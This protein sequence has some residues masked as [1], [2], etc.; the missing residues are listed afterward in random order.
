M[1]KPR[2]IREIIKAAGGDAAVAAAVSTEAKQI[3][4]DAVYKWQFNGIPD[5]YW[6]T[7]IP[8]AQTTPAELFAANEAVRAEKAAA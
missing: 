7:I 5:R 4:S 6:S 2:T 8:I 1:E 3:K